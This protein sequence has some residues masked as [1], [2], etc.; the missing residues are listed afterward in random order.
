M[1]NFSREENLTESLL[2]DILKTG[3]NNILIL[4]KKPA[5]NV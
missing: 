3:E 5:W 2:I 4:L 1:R